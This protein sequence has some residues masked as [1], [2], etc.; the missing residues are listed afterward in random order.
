MKLEGEGQLLRIFIG[1]SDHWQNRPLHEEIVRL[2]RESGLAGATVL[3]GVEGFGASSRL[4]TT[5]LL[6]LSQDLPLV[7][8]VVDTEERIATVLP[9]LDEMVRE[10]MMT[11]ER[12]HIISYRGRD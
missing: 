8:E 10:G 12:V 11:I 7:I 9:R 3:R 2:F 5:R 4:H 1:E 6:Q